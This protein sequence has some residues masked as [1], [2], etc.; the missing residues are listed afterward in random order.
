[1][2]KVGT[3]PNAKKIQKD[4]KSTNIQSITDIKLEQIDKSKIFLMDEKNKGYRVTYKMGKLKFKITNAKIPFGVEQYNNK[5]ILNIEL[6]NNNNE[7]NNLIHEINL[8]GSIYEQFSKPTPNNAPSITQHKLPFVPL[9]LNFIKSVTYKEFC[10]SLK[11]IINN[12]TLD[13]SGV[14]FRTHTKTNIEIYK[15]VDNELIQI[16]SAELKGKKCDFEVEFSNIWIH[17][18]KYGFIWYV[19]KIICN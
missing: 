7:H 6:L 16:T 13:N 5:D 19:T 18:N 3:T 9:P 8:I 1:M 14:F 4:K 2:L 11:P 17:G 15:K 12:L 10:P